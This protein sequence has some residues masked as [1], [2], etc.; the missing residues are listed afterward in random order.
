MVL[1]IAIVVLCTS[2]T[3]VFA[4][5]TNSEIVEIATQN[6]INTFSVTYIENGAITTIS[7]SN[8]EALVFEAG[9]IS[10]VVA[11]YICMQLIEEE[12]LHLDD[13]IAQYLSDDWITNDAR[14]EAITIRQLLSHTA[15]FSPSFEMGVDRRVYFEPGSRF[16][17]SGVGYIYLQQILENTT[18]ETFEQLAQ[19]Y[20]FAPLNMH[21]STFENVRTVT[22]F[23]NA[24]SLILYT[25]VVWSAIILILF[26]LGGITG[27][28]TKF[29]YFDKKTLFFTC[30][31][32][33]FIFT[34]ILL[35]IMGSVISRMIVPLSLFGLVGF[36][37]LW[38]FRKNQKLYY[39][40]FS[41]YI[42]LCLTFGFLLPVSLPVG[43]ILSQSPNAAYSL[44]STSEDLALFADHL[45][46]AYHNETTAT[47]W[48]FDEQIQIDNNGWGLGLSLEVVGGV[49]T[50]WHSG[51]NPGMQSLFVMN[52][53][54]NTAVVIMTNSDNG[55]MFATSIAH[56]I[57]EVEGEWQIERIDLGR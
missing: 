18:G 46:S 42:L 12:I 2:T 23:V 19:R 21:N 10:K 26:I 27:L 4:N 38:L 51:I 15:G 6:N 30:V 33:G 35:V 44:K 3:T 14:F 28:I 39:V 29:R 55:L 24:S 25:V 56:K 43:Q 7:N 11:A 16:S 8:R 45:L 40:V 49:T 9:S 50:Y 31:S 5:I 34:F 53:Q 32:A 47:R 13:T 22:P 36:I 41:G 20:V 57:L 37:I 54:S 48:M 52:P 1:I 17:Y